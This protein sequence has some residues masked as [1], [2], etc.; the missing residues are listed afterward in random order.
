[1]IQNYKENNKMVT[2]GRLGLTPESRNV[3]FS[4][5]ME[6]LSYIAYICNLC[7]L[8]HA[9]MFHKKKLMNMFCVLY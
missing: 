2:E 9:C 7:I 6:V 5:H 4:G 3:V 8:L 1:M